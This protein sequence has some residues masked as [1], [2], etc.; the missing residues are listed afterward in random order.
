MFTT[1]APSGRASQ[2][3]APVKL[4]PEDHAPWCLIATWRLLHRHVRA[5][6]CPAQLRR[7]HTDFLCAVAVCVSRPQTHATVCAQTQ[8]PDRSRPVATQGRAVIKVPQ[9]TAALSGFRHIDRHGAL[10]QLGKYVGAQQGVNG[11][12]P[13]ARVG[14]RLRKQSATPLLLPSACRAEFARSNPDQRISGCI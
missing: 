8:L 11:V 7:Q 6:Q 2:I 10:Q 3:K 1:R 9:C 14:V 5:Q 4:S 13:S 12:R